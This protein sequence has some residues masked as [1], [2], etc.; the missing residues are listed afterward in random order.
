MPGNRQHGS[1]TACYTTSLLACLLS[2][3][4]IISII[5][6]TQGAAADPESPDQGQVGAINTQDRG[7]VARAFN[8]IYRPTWDVGVGWTGDAQRCVAGTIAPAFSQAQLTQLNFYR[9]MVGLPGNVTYRADYTAK[10][11][12]AALIMQANGTLSHSPPPQWRCLT[13][14]GISGAQSSNLGNLGSSSCCHMEQ[15]LEDPGANNTR[16]GHRSWLLNPNMQATGYGSTGS[17]GALWVFDSSGSRPAQPEWY[18]WPPR[19]YVPYHLVFDRWSFTMPGSDPSAAE[20]S[21]TRNRQPVDVEVVSRTS[22]LVW[23]PAGLPSYPRLPRMDSD[24]TFEVVI[25]GI[26]GAS[27]STVRYTVTVF[28]PARAAVGPSPT[29]GRITTSTASPTPPRARTATPSATA[30]SRATPR[31][32]SPTPTVAR[33]GDPECN[34]SIDGAG[35]ANVRF[36]N[37]GRRPVRVRWVDFDCDRQARATIQPGE[38]FLTTSR[39]G[40]TWEVVDAAT[41]IELARLTPWSDAVGYRVTVRPNASAPVAGRSRVILDPPMNWECDCSR[42]T[43]V[44]TTLTFVNGARDTLG[45]YWYRQGCAKVKYS[46]IPSTLQIEQ[47]TYGSH[48]WQVGWARSMPASGALADVSA[49]A[50]VPVDIA[51]ESIAINS[52]T[53]T[54]TPTPARTPTRTATAMLAPT[55]TRTATA[56]SPLPSAS[57]TRTP[58]QPPSSPGG[59]VINLST[60]ARVGIGDHVLIGGFVV[61][62]ARTQVLIRA[63]GPSLANAGVSG[64]LD[65]PTV[66]LHRGQA[67][68]AFNDDWGD[69]DA[70]RI[71]AT[72]FPPQHPR[73]SAILVELDPGLYTAIVRGYAGGTGVGLVEIFQTGG[74]GS[75]L[76]L[77]ARERVGVGDDVAIGGFVVSGRRTRILLRGIGPEL[78]KAGVSDPLGDPVLTLYSGSTKIAWNDDWG[79]SDAERIRATGLAPAGPRESA[80]LVDLDP[81][82]YTAIL[83]GYNDATGVAL[84]EAFVLGAP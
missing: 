59:R 48:T 21:V 23:E 61:S 41:E 37:A 52:P 7:A 39:I 74:G 69:G 67:Q 1:R 22:V 34:C 28:D 24:D 31:P 45:A 18:S 38:S 58:I 72:G 71:G 79:L 6:S 43:L 32:G 4:S 47:P 27:A 3:A 84:V 51:V 73:E 40:N 63:V 55:A 10:A 30:T 25:S 83:S 20:V 56:R 62:G 2:T 11:Q 5:L 75:L 13:A 19:G 46:E 82:L 64:V 81:G 80:L 49:D 12:A 66:A 35:T 29:T 60:R 54:A 53:F 42:W 76:N 70:A 26:T 78:A 65:D 50:D 15:W 36:V 16:V 44:N 17:Y 68:L 8:T 77:S 9:A 33:S 57:P 14:E